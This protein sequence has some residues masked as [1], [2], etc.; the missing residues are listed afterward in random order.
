[1][2]D[3]RG[4]GMPPVY[5]DTLLGKFPQFARFPGM[6]W[7]EVCKVLA[8]LLE[9]FED[10]HTRVPIGRAT[11]ATAAYRK[12]TRTESLTS[13]HIDALVRKLVTGHPVLNTPPEAYFLAQR[14]K[15]GLVIARAMTNPM[16]GTPAGLALPR[17]VTSPKLLSWLLI[18]VW[19][20]TNRFVWRSILEAILR[21]QA[22]SGA[23][24][25]AKFK[26]K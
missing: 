21:A 6:N 19:R 1:M 16:P 13:R 15:Y 18:D 23:A 4:M 3:S 11:S 7:N 9:R 17:S 8:V 10:D 2:Q 25:E 20:S 24:V 14:L 5:L 26:T 22:S 12:V